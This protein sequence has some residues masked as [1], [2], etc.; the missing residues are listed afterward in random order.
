MLVLSRR[1]G[2]KIVIGNEIIIEVLSVTGD[3]VRLGIAAPK[4]TSV[5][6]FEVFSEI[7]KANQAAEAASGDLE[8]STALE[9]LSA[10]LKSQQ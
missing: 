2:E 5:H 4:E 10:K 6:R 9:N 7:E 3:G 1:E 8:S